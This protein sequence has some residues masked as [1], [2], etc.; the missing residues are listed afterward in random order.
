MNDM[1][2]VIIPK[3]DQINADTLLAGPIT[4]KISNVVIEPG[5]EQPVSISFDGDDGR[6]YKP[7]KSMRKVMVL[8]WGKDANEYVGR[9]MTL[10]NDP[11]VTWGDMTVGGIRISH[12]SNIDAVATMALTATRR[13]KKPFTVRPLVSSK[14]ETSP[15][16]DK[17]AEGVRDL[18]DRI[19]DADQATLTV[20]TMDTRIVTQ[21]AWL[22]TNRPELAARVDDAVSAALGIFDAADA[23]DLAA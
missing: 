1:S 12:M 7:C 3:S 4:I 22:A 14:A 20:L 2:Q 6:P 15:A 17:A 13:S 23:G 10:Y 5:T 11:K 16:P 8:L 18:I 9:S 21:R 19:Q